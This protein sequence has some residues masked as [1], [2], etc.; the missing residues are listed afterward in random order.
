MIIYHSIAYRGADR[1]VWR[2]EWQKRSVR[3]RHRPVGR[4]EGIRSV[5]DGDKDCGRL[6]YGCKP[7]SEPGKFDA[8]VV[9]VPPGVTEDATRILLKPDVYRHKVVANGVTTEFSGDDRRLYRQSVG[10][11]YELMMGAVVPM[12][13]GASYIA[14][15]GVPIFGHQ[16]HQAADAQQAEAAEATGTPGTAPAEPVQTATGPEL[17]ERVT[18]LEIDDEEEDTRDSD[19][20]SWPELE[21]MDMTPGTDVTPAPAPE[22]KRLDMIVEERS[23]ADIGSSISIDDAAKERYV[24]L[25]REMIETMTALGQDLAGLQ[26]DRLV[27]LNR[28]RTI[29]IGSSDMFRPYKEMFGPEAGAS[30]Q[31]LRG[32]MAEYCANNSESIK[33]YDIKNMDV[34]WVIDSFL[35]K[36]GHVAFCSRDEELVKSL[37]GWAV[38][39]SHDRSFSETVDIKTACLRMNGTTLHFVGEAAREVFRKCYDDILENYSD[40]FLQATENP[41]R[42]ATGRRKKIL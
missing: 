40:L 23:L 5:R 33:V 35:P 10:N 41:D 29:N 16:S 14:Q 20:D 13:G 19:V 22:P 24:A 36:Q 18:V 25:E 32:L 4:V 3:A 6:V 9:F 17:E 7:G 31:E 12:N 15:E 39:R 37:F 11:M 34:L 2:R 28:D 30:V 38:A 8:R 21:E 26:Y 42:G 1:D 27:I